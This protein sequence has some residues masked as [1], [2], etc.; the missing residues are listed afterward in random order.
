[1]SE[2]KIS[3]IIRTSLENIKG[4]VGADTVIG[5]AITCPGGTVI[6]PVSKVSIGLASGGLDFNGKKSPEQNFG[7]A[8]GTGVSVTP[9]AFLIVKSSGEVELLS[10]D[11]PTAPGSEDSLDNL[12]NFIKTSPDLVKRFREAFAKKDKKPA[13]PQDEAGEGSGED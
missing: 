3:D 6:I 4:A 12:L 1:M 9:L 13:E 7:G 8:G 10:V 11:N 5:E 2:N